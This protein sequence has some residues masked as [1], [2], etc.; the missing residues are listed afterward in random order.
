MSDPSSTGFGLDQ[1]GP[2]IAPEQLARL[3]ADTRQPEALAVI[4]T[5]TAIA[6]ITLCMRYF[7]RVFLVK[8]PGLDDYLIAIAMA[9]PSTKTTSALPGTDFVTPTSSWR[10]L[11]C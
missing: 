7:T 9:S 11:E 4:I 6:G 2:Q 5:F 3:R 8:K 10:P 1:S